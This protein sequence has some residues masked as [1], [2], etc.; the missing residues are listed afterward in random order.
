MSQAELQQH[1]EMVGA[2][3]HSNRTEPETGAIQLTVY[4]T[5]PGIYGSGVFDNKA[6]TTEQLIQ[7]IQK[8]YGKI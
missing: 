2:Y 8:A 1:Q 4:T 3:Y 5:W 7:L 6:T